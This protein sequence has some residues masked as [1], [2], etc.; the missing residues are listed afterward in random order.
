MNGEDEEKGATIMWEFAEMD[1]KEVEFVG[2]LSGVENRKDKE[3]R[4]KWYLFG[5]YGSGRQAA[6]APNAQYLDIYVTKE[7]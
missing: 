7:I 2:V 1:Q 5:V 4:T 3:K 6:A